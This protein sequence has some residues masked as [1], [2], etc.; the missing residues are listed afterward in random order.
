M[1]TSST[2]DMNIWLAILFMSLII[3]IPVLWTIAI[4]HSAYIS[5]KYLDEIISS[6]K[7]SPELSSTIKL[8]ASLG[9]S[10][11]IFIPGLLHTWMSKSRFTSIGL[12]SNSDIENFPHHIKTA[13]SKNNKLYKISLT[14][15]FLVFLIVLFK[16][17]PEPS[18][19]GAIQYLA[20][21]KSTQLTI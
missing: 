11:R 10:R 7:H 8:Y 17:L 16:N 12:I 9:L 4:A 5:N 19:S 18:I 15:T 13:I 6:I 1:I 20:P 3:T 14:W 2:T 21:M